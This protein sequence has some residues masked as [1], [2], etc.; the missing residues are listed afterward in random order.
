[1]KQELEQAI[2]NVCKNVFN[3]DIRVELTR[4]DQQFG[5]YATNVALQL[6]KQLGKNPEK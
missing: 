3:V 2:A 6:A 1:M 5:D 4:P